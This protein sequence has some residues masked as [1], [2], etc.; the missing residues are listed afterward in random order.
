VVG[1]HG[2]ALYEPSVAM[3]VWRQR[4]EQ[5]AV[6]MKQVAFSVGLLSLGLAVGCDNLPGC[7]AVRP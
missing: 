1:R 5:G 7:G 6:Y 2:K 4:I 3:P